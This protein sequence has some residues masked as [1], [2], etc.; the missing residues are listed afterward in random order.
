MDSSIVK[1][2]KASVNCGCKVSPTLQVASHGGPYFY[3][4]DK[5]N[6]WEL[7]PLVSKSAGLSADRQ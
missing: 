5:I 2:V 7:M 1:V 6:C 4:V 3:T